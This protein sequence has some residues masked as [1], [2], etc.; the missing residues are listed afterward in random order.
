MLG[1]WKVEAVRKG[2]IT[3]VCGGWNE[4]RL[5]G[6]LKEDRKN[7]EDK[8]YIVRRFYLMWYH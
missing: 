1:N 2:R 7:S 3:R 5:L 8:S 6:E 4:G